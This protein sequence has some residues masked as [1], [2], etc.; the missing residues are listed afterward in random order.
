MRKPGLHR[1]AAARSGLDAERA[2]AEL[3]PRPHGRK[4]GAGRAGRR[5]A[6][7]ETAA[8]VGDE[9]CAAAVAF[10]QRHRDARGLRVLAHV[11]ERL[12]GDAEEIAE[13]SVAGCADNV[14]SKR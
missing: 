10:Q 11:L 14:S 5:E 13:A 1:R 8:V 7:V 6:R 4:A 3:R 12:L 2:A 9:D